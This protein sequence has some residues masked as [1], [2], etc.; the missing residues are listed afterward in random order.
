M[1]AI[2][3]ASTKPLERTK[4]RADVEA[5][6]LEGVT[7]AEIARRVGV[8]RSAIGYFRKRHAAELASHIAA[9]ERRIEDAAI[10]DKVQRILDA[11][12]DY[13]R[14]GQV[15]AARAS[16]TRYEEPGYKTGTMVHQYRMVGGGK[17][18]R[19]VDEYK[20]DAALIAERRALRRQVAEE[21]DQL[22]RSTTNVNI[23]ARSIVVRYVEG[24]ET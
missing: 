21:L 12:S 15:I 14:L 6:I 5:W 4:I 13:Q 9:V 8:H 20:V 17:N 11:D 1:G 10:A 19:L 23:D 22:P 2:R 7:D 24:P 18:A 3:A 16:D